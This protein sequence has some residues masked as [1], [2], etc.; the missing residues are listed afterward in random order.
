MTTG[1]GFRGSGPGARDH[2]AAVVAAV[3]VLF[4][5]VLFPG[6]IPQC[7]SER[8]V[9]PDGAPQR[10]AER[11]DHDG[12]CNSSFMIEQFKG[13]TKSYSIN[14]KIF[15][16]AL[17]AGENASA[18]LS[19]APYP[20]IIQMPYAGS[21]EG[22]YDFISPRMVSWG[23]ICCVVG[24][25]QS[26]GAL[27]SGNVQDM[28]EILDQLERDNSTP[29]HNLNGMVDAGAFG[30]GGHSYGGR[31]S[32]I[33]GCYVPRIRAVQAMAPAIY[34]SEVN[35]I[36]P[37][38]RKPVQIQVGRLDTGI[39]STSQNAYGAFPPPKAIIDLPVGHGGPFLWD[40]AIAFFFYHLRA[41]DAYGTFLYG[42]S[43][44]KDASNLTYYLNFSLPNGS[45]FPPGIMLHAGTTAPHEDELV[46]FTA[47]H[48][49]LLPLG[50]PN[51]TFRW[52]LDGDA[53]ADEGGPS[54]LSANR[55]YPQ[56]RQV[57]VGAWYEMG[58]LRLDANNTLV[59]LVTNLPPTAQCGP[60]RIAAEDESVAFSGVGTDTPSD[61]GSL[62]FS[63]DFGDGS[64]SPFSP[65]VNASHSY[66][67]VGNH[68]VRLTVRDGDG[69]MGTDGLQIAVS[70]L[71][72]AA[73]AVGNMTVWKDAELQFTGKG[74]D[75][76]SDLSML[77]YRW[78]FGDGAISDWSVSPGAVHTYT[79]SGNLSAAFMVRDGDGAEAS[80]RF[81]VW[82]KNAA[83]SAYVRLPPE[84]QSFL[85]DDDVEF[86]GGGTDTASDVSYMTFSW[87]FGDG[88]KTGW[89]T[90]AGAVH[91][92]TRG[93]RYNA[94]LRAQDPEGAV[95]S[96]AVNLT[97][98]NEP[99]S[100]RLLSPGGSAFNEDEDVRFLA[101]ADDSESDRQHLSFIWEIDGVIHSGRDIHR[102][103]S[104]EG[105]HKYA[106]KVLDH[107]G[108]S[109]IARGSVT[110]INPA[111][112]LRASL[113]PV[114]IQAG[115]SVNF[116]AGSSDTASDLEN[117]SFSWKFG[118]GTGSTQD[119]GSHVYA[120]PG[121]YMVKV[122][123]EDDED[124]SAEESFTV[125]VDARPATPPPA[126]GQPA[127]TNLSPTV[128][129]GAVC[130]VA[131][132]GLAMVF[133]LRPRTKKA[134]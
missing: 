95:S 4:M 12:P 54:M 48:D 81:R 47:S 6:A 60:G 62:N 14:L 69:A 133:I 26:D 56:A 96:A 75:T 79:R 34:Q 36:A 55:S 131:A 123:V 18:N 20:T 77:Q 111:P 94:V 17:A 45:F 130:A 46:N 84:S 74:T 27:S 29:G 41:L 39:F 76:P 120:S 113:S 71:P 80:S 7:G 42:D 23:L 16:P 126:G 107:E 114:K 70:N 109:T 11:P 103:F 10:A 101:E 61:I 63:W 64:S 115:G 13:S 122:T 51:C 110:I 125:T 132:A 98:R 100:V 129:V 78:D 52:D 128:I 40:L 66:G 116:S 82:V 102:S 53:I 105:T 89:A 88:N 121:T 43:A 50:R 38:F 104:T 25:N 90:S 97:I 108:A 87:D 15:Y 58:K 59:L 28:T 134:P 31:Q 33:D 72:P 30:I 37:V 35:A 21:D 3:S 44:L 2:D 106:L 99:P 118:D 91:S 8:P 83:P 93:G 57:R 24:V 68:S 19:G 22:A 127:S 124:A 117:L 73:S 65:E 67:K 86:D 92:Y 119:T 9:Q 5:T 85:K 49:G 112:N 32:L 1:F